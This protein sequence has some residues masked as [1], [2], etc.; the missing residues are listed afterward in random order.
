MEQIGFSNLTTG[1]EYTQ[2][3]ERVMEAV[4]EFFKPEF[5]N[6][7]DETIIFDVLSKDEVKAIVG[8]QIDILA[9]RLLEKEIILEVTPEAVSQISEKSYDP[10]YGARPIKRFIQTHILNQ[11]ASLML[12][13]K[14]SKGSIAEVSL[15]K[16]GAIFIEAKKPRK[17]PSPI[18]KAEMMKKGS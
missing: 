11:I 6:R 14:F 12:S 2:V 15:D 17:I 1:G 10:H 18:T 5:L 4:K 16:K 8:L 3:K 13:K 9:K 7:L